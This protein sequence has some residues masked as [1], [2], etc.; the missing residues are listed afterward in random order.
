MRVCVCVCVCRYLEYD[1]YEE[2]DKVCFV[3]PDV[4]QFMK[5]YEGDG[6]CV[7]VC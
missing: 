2:S 4:V 1:V 3:T 5:L 6:K 7:C